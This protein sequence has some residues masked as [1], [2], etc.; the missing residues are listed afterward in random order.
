M[1]TT[2]ELDTE[3]DTARILAQKVAAQRLEAIPA[4]FLSKDG[5]WLYARLIQ[6]EDHPRLLHLFGLLSSQARRRRFHANVDRLSAETIDHHAYDFATVD[7]LQTGGAVVAV[8]FQG[9]VQKIVGVLRLA[10]R[11]R[12]ALRSRWSCAM[13]FRGAGWGGHCFNVCRHW[14]GAWM[15]IRSS[16]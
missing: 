8:D 7:N 3:L 15:C 11:S 5:Y 9:T 10:R 16:P 4:W 12:V 14:R 2:D 1:D 6:P 13:I